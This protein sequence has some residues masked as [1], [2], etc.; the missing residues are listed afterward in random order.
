MRRISCQ[1]QSWFHV[2]AP[3][4]ASYDPCKLRDS[5]RFLTT[6]IITTNRIVHRFFCLFCNACAINFYQT[7]H[8]NTVWHKRIIQIYTFSL[9][10][11]SYPSI[12]LI[13]GLN[14]NFYYL[15]LVLHKSSAGNIRYSC[16]L[17]GRIGN[18]Y[19]VKN[20]TQITPNKQYEKIFVVRIN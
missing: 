17:L 15:H 4:K 11:H 10:F 6:T 7:M 3:L 19:V 20:A 13:V 9:H 8:L 1:H 14:R 16:P 2:T 12:A 5:H 18:N